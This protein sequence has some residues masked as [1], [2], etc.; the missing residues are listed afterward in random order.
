MLARWRSFGDVRSEMNRL[1]D[2]MNRLFERWSP[3][4]ETGS[5]TFGMAMTPLLDLWED[6]AHIYVEAELPGLDLDDL[7]IYVTGENQLSIKGQRKQPDMN[8]GKWHR[9]ERGYGSFTRLIE[10]PTHVAADKVS[11]DFKFGVLTIT[12]PKSAQ[13][14]ARRISVKPE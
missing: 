1:N 6:E 8:V 4:P 9:Q 12:L 13:A 14:K 5:R 2:E 7:E 10:L 3:W 11:A